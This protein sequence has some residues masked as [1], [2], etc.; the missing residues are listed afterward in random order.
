MGILRKNY[1][2]DAYF[3]TLDQFY[4]ITNM[5]LRYCNTFKINHN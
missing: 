5:D 3:K 4:Y 1:K 2:T